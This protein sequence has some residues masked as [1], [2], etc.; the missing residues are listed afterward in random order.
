M[1][2]AFDDVIALVDCRIGSLEIGLCTCLGLALVD[3]RIGSLEIRDLGRPVPVCVD[4]R[5]GSLETPT[6]QF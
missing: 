1:A 3:C 2:L 4:C 6:S 5:I